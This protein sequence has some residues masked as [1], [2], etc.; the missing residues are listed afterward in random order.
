MAEVITFTAVTPGQLGN[1]I[2]VEYVPVSDGTTVILS[3]VESD[4]GQVTITITAGNSGTPFLN[5]ADW[6][7]IADAMNADP[8]VSALIFSVGS[9]A[10]DA[11]LS[12]NSNQFLNGTAGGGLTSYFFGLAAPV[13]AAVLPQISAGFVGPFTRD[14]LT[15]NKWDCC[16]QEEIPL[17]RT[18]DFE[19]PACP[20]P[21][22]Q[23]CGECH[24]N[25]D[26][27]PWDERTNQSQQLKKFGSIVTPAP[28]DALVMTFKV[29]LGYAG[30]IRS[31]V[32]MYTGTGFIQGSGDIIWRLQIA[33]RWAKDY[34]NL[35]VQL[36]S[37]REPFPTDI[38]LVSGQIVSWYVNVVNASGQIQVGNSRIACFVNGWVY[39]M[40][41]RGVRNQRVRLAV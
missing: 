6:Q 9:A 30:V 35:Q 22:P 32:T 21:T 12:G 5:V 31:L 28:G 33:R 25:G 7:A 26:E 3:V 13:A 10:N 2:D 19:P 36:G 29:P 8:D 14:Y 1:L 15:P 41:E 37:T 38:Y 27:P 20:I 34:G 17:M 40:M 23:E 39:P 24:A 4:F 11:I 18:V 16:L